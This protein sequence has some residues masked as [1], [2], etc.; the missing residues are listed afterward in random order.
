MSQVQ[1]ITKYVCSIH[2]TVDFDVRISVMRSC[3]PP[4]ESTTNFTGIEIEKAI[5]QSSWESRS[6]LRSIPSPYFVVS[7][8][9]ALTRSPAHHLRDQQKNGVRKASHGG[10]VASQGTARTKTNLMN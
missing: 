7:N 3:G 6:A 8:G 1:Y 9:R 2:S 4:Y 10:F 5:N